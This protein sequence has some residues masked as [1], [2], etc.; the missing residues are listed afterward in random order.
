M[1]VKMKQSHSPS[2]SWGARAVYGV[3]PAGYLLPLSLIIMAPPTPAA[4]PGQLRAYPRVE[5]IG[6]G[7]FGNLFDDT[8]EGTITGQG[9]RCQVQRTC[10]SSIPNTACSEYPWCSPSKNHHPLKSY[11]TLA[12]RGGKRI[13]PPPSSI[14]R[15]TQKR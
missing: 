8:P 13:T 7:E 10:P 6:V 5:I 12:W 14:M 3:I 4:S 1:L 9:R 15:A 11:S 2:S